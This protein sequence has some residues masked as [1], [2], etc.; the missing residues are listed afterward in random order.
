MIIRVTTS[1]E[2]S[3]EIFYELVHHGAGLKLIPGMRSY[4]KHRSNRRI[5]AEYLQ[6]VHPMTHALSILSEGDFLDD[7]GGLKTFALEQNTKKALHELYSSLTVPE[8]RFLSSEIIGHAAATLSNTITPLITADES[9]DLMI[10]WTEI[11]DFRDAKN[12]LGILDY[13]REVSNHLEEHHNN[14]TAADHVLHLRC[15][16]RKGQLLLRKNYPT[17]QLQSDLTDTV[18]S[19]LH[20]GLSKN[21]S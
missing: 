14:S 19:P 7:K 9:N 13:A 1:G 16:L 4:L 18:N 6:G 11:F 5:N 3:G 20:C 10:L 15:L 8:F 2:A 21:D 17:I 12:G